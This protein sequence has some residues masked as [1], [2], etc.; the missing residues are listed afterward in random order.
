MTRN[1]LLLAILLASCDAINRDQQVKDEIIA[2]AKRRSEAVVKSDIKTLE[3]ILDRDFT[4][5][6]T[7]GK[8]LSRKEYLAGQGLLGN[9]D[10]YWISQTMDSIDVKLVNSSALVTFR[11]NDRFVFEKVEYSNFCRSTFLYE[12]KNGKWSCVMGHTTQI[13]DDD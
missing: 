11:I 4:Y 2:L 1:I 3:E 13:N 9:A 6:N 10:S 5:V 8:F 7:S 12:R